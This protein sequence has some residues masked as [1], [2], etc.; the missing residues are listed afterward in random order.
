[1]GKRAAAQAALGPTKKDYSAFL[2]PDKAVACPLTKPGEALAAVKEGELVTLKDWFKAGFEC[3][4]TKEELGSCGG[5]S[6]LGK[7]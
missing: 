7:G 5:C 4:D 1:M 3:L 6:S 2:C